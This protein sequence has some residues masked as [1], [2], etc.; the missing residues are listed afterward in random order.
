MATPPVGDATTR[1]D[2]RARGKAAL[3]FNAWVVGGSYSKNRVKRNQM[4]IEQV[5]RK[6][7]AGDEIEAQLLAKLAAR[8]EAI[9]AE[10]AKELKEY[11]PKVAEAFREDRR[12][13]AAERSGRSPRRGDSRGS[14]KKSPRKPSRPATVEG[15]RAAEHDKALDAAR[16][17]RTRLKES[18]EQTTQNHLYGTLFPPLLTP[19]AR[20]MTF[21]RQD[22]SG[23]AHRSP[24]ADPNFSVPASAAA[25]PKEP[26]SLAAQRPK[27][28]QPLT[29]PKAFM[30][31]GS[32]TTAYR[33][34]TNYGSLAR[35]TS[36]AADEEQLATLLSTTSKV[37]PPA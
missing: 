37:A 9:R 4:K 25:P 7:D 28:A 17:L 2:V 19:Y 1:L 26:F 16:T 29:G 27:R 36:N 33:H 21:I 10:Q 8:K 6:E 24:R 30:P 14:P 35:L 3:E 13:E 23:A 31:T 34:F 18:F 22:A 12:V 15:E 5:R 11:K 20:P 32:S